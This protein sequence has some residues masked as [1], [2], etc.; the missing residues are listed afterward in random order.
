MKYSAYW[1]Y[2]TA[3]Y[4][5]LLNQVFRIRTILSALSTQVKLVLQKTA[6]FKPGSLFLNFLQRGN[7]QHFPRPKWQ[8]H[9]PLISWKKTT[10]FNPKGSIINF[11][12][13]DNMMWVSSRYQK[14]NQVQ[15][16]FHKNILH[17]I[18]FTTFFIISLLHIGSY[19]R[20]SSKTVTWLRPI[21]SF[22]IFS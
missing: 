19:Y 8:C 16:F 9:I 22:W 15:V 7:I 3:V 1:K 20:C 11:L 12:C 14:N 4:M 13:K 21:S 10:C 6:M 5:N 17:N 18:F 2:V